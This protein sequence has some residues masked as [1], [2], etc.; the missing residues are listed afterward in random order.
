MSLSFTLK[1]LPGS[2]EAQSNAKLTAN[3]KEFSCRFILGFA[4][5]WSSHSLA[6]RLSAVVL[7][8]RP[9]V[10]F[11]SELEKENQPLEY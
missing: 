10:F 8:A 2:S 11:P 9:C 5:S 4:L 7:E 3:F 6:K 1:D